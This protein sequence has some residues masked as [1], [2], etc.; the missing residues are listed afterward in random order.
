MIESP[1]VEQ[2]RRLAQSSPWRWTT[3]ELEFVPPRHTDPVHAWI[4]RPGSL[5][6]EKA[7]GQIDELVLQATPFA[8]TM[9]V[10]SDGESRHP[11]ARWASDTTPEYDAD[12]LV[13][14]LPS[15]ADSWLVDWDDPFYENYQWIAMLNPIEIARSPHDH[16]STKVCTELSCGATGAAPRQTCLAGHRLHHT[17]V[18]PAVRMLCSA[19]WTLG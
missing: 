4:R 2:F 5:R 12:G 15:E 7:D 9:V 13:S 17:R 19:E 3:V 1:S 16:S 11:E 10:Y 6:V 18:R 14:A 8:N